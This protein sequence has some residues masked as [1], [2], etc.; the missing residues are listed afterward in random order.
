MWWRWP[1]RI[2]AAIGIALVALTAFQA[3]GDVVTGIRYAP[4]GRLVDVGGYRIHV[5][6]S[7]DV[8]AGPTI[9]LEAAPCSASPQWGWIQPALSRG[10]RVA[11]YDRPGLGWSDAAPGPLSPRDL[12]RAL[13]TALERAG[14]SPPYVLV[15]HSAGGLFALEF[16]ALYPGDVAGLVLLDA[17]GPAMQALWPGDI[18]SADLARWN[19][20]A[21]LARLGLI[22]ASG[23]ADRIA[24]GLPAPSRDE[25][26]ALLASSRHLAACV[27]DARIADVA[28]RELRERAGLGELPLLVLSAT[29]ADGYVFR[30]RK[31][32]DLFSDLQ[33]DFLGLSTR[34]EQKVVNAADQITLVT[35]AGYARTVTDAIRSFTLSLRR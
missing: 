10:A 14:A 22:R 7:G 18:V 16:A 26:G 1:V 33:R 11:S 19:P 23:V 8:G 12:A 20:L 15:G 32:R 34:S 28:A 21:Y 30:D 31:T 5:N 17:R 35:D 29:D 27:P 4:P 13:R 3:V 6:L 25:E 24:A 9:V 2:L